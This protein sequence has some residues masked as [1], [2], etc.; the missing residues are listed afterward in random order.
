MALGLNTGLRQSQ[1]RP[2]LQS[3]IS[4]CWAAKLGQG[5]PCSRAWKMVA[6]RQSV[7]YC[8]G[9]AVADGPSQKAL[10]P[11]IPTAQAPEREHLQVRVQPRLL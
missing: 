6:V 7:S 1:S 11:S 4:C 2:Q 10:G 5:A 9:V 3:Q 8:T